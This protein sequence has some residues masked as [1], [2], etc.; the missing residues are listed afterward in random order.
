MVFPLVNL[1]DIKSLKAEALIKARGAW[2]T[3]LSP[4]SADLIP[5][6]MAFSK[7]KA[8]LRA[9]AIRTIDGLWQV[10]GDIYDL[11]SRTECPKYVT[12]AGYRFTRMH[13]ALASL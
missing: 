11:Y 12:T 9:R 10:I 3:F 1:S 4:Y 2:M 13:A 6:E 7:L 5:I 8:H